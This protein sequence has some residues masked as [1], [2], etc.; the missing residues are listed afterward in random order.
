MINIS[1]FLF[2]FLLS[3]YLH[4]LNVNSKACFYTAS[5]TTVAITNT[6]ITHVFMNWLMIILNRTA[7]LILQIH[8]IQ[9]K[10]KDK[11]TNAYQTK[12]AAILARFTQGENEIMAGKGHLP[13]VIHSW[14]ILISS[15]IVSLVIRA[16]FSS[17]FIYVIFY[18]FDFAM[19]TCYDLNACVN[20]VF[21]FFFVRIQIWS[22]LFWC[23]K[24]F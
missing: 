8:F 5:M 15:A 18:V 22:Y 24:A 17:I 16:F 12:M 13:D 14:F 1:G 7:V 6:S 9:V 20:F 11:I 10:L 3:L 4:C 23:I 2:F 19:L 21:F